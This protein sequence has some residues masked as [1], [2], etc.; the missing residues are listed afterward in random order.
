MGIL[1][2]IPHRGNEEVVGLGERWILK[3]HK[4]NLEEVKDVLQVDLR[5][6]WE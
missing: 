6:S 1:I 2:M 4:L 3:P 5:V